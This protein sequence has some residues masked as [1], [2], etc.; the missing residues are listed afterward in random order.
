MS[1]S[2][3]QLEK[4]ESIAFLTKKREF[5]RITSM[6]DK[7]L[8][9]DLKDRDDVSL[10][11]EI[12]GEFVA[13]KSNIYG[14]KPRGFR[15]ELSDRDTSM[16]PLLVQI[17]IVEYENAKITAEH[18]KVSA[19]GSISYA[20]QKKLDLLKP[21]I[22]VFLSKIQSIK[23]GLREIDKSSVFDES[24]KRSF[25]MGVCE[26]L[27]AGIAENGKLKGKAVKALYNEVLVKTKR[28]TASQTSN[29]KLK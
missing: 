23:K 22:D 13:Q 17:Q 24:Q 9:I 14:N 18:N 20:D 6:L 27:T 12:L 25:I 8:Y 21:D 11:N 4:Q 26:E 10:E 1:L 28:I 16:I 3:E 2:A 29:L 7:C 19:A 15:Y 5:A